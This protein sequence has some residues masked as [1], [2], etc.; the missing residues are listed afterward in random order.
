MKFE[1]YILENGLTLLFNK[2]TKT[3][4]AVVNLIYKVGSKN[5]EQNKTGY[6]HLLEHLMFEGSVNV[7]D[8]DK[9]IDKSSGANNAF[10]NNDYTNYYISLPKCNIENALWVESDRMMNLLFDKKRFKTQKNVVIEEFKQTSLN[11]PYGDDMELLV[12]IAYKKHSY[13]WRTIGKKIAHIENATRQ[14]LIDF[15]NNNYTP[16]NAILS[17]GGNFEFDYVKKIVE[18]WFADIPNKK[19]IV[20][21]IPE[22]PEQTE[23]REK[24]VK[25]DV[26]YNEL[27]MAFHIGGRIS[28]DFYLMDV[29]TDILDAGKSSRFN[30]NLIKKDHYFEELDAYVTGNIDNGLLVINGRPANGYSLKDGEKYIWNEINKL[31]QTEVEDSELLKSINSLEFGLGYMKTNIMS[32]TRALSYYELLGD[33][34]LINNE[35][36][37]YSAI[38]KKELLDASKRIFDENKVSVLYYLKED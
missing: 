5:E 9:V 14:D 33:I 29:I 7:K 6:A 30:Q 17:I 18:K 23:R 38:N 3:P 37:I 19:R 31:K 11:E 4:L 35:K 25:R 13:R 28:R 12:D 10:T 21:V 32:K 36:E 2:D 24:T 15:Y 26:P 20:N 16:N 27:Y 1:K 22:E 34:D 8:F